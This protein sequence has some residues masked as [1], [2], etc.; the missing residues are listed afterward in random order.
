ME[1]RLIPARRFWAVYEGDTLICLTVYKKGGRAV[2]N[3]LLQLLED[4]TDD[5]KKECFLEPAHHA[6]LP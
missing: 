5:R 4:D 2:I 1:F 3:R 6:S